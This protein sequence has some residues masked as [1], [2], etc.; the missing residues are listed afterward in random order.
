[1]S[2]Q[3]AYRSWSQSMTDLLTWQW[4]LFEIP[5]QAS[6]K[7][8]EA[9][10]RISGKSK[11]TSGDRSNAVASRTHDVHAL[12]AQALE[13]ARCGRALP[14]EVYRVP[15]RDRIDWSRFP[16]WARPIDPEVFEGSG[17]EG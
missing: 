16:G 11:P 9:A 3:M 13:C 4:R 14:R 17:H 2:T 5:Y 1:M 6:L 10:L 15:Y 8:A 12:E 7:M